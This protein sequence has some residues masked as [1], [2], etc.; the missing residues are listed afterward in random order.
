MICINLLND[1]DTVQIAFVQ[2][3]PWAFNPAKSVKMFLF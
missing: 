3:K 2:V 1:D